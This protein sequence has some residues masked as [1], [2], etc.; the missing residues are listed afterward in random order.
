MRADGRTFD[1]LR[2]VKIKIDYLD[3][4]EASAFIEVGKTRVLAAASI[5]DRVPPFLKNSGSGWV[6]AEYSMLPCSTEKRT[7]RERNLTRI[8]G[9]S[10]EIQRLI[11]RSLRSVTDLDSVG[12]RTII[13]D[14]DVIQADGGTRAASITAACVALAL[15]FK[16]L[17]DEKALSRMPLKQLVSGVSVGIVDGEP[18]L[19]L[20]YQEDSKAD[21]DMNVVE[22]SSGKLV[23]VQVTAEKNPFSRKELNALLKLADK[24]IKELIEVQKGVLKKKNISFK[25]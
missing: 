5:E 12:E 9:R 25:G 20:D 1:E 18:L 17:L 7:L 10:Q 3:F 15:V 21:I 2:P 22:T 14:C 16:K 11:G 6:T 24:G 23:E 13:L 4:A 19:D 8:S